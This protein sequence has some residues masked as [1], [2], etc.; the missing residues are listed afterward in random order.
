MSDISFFSSEDVTCPVCLTVFKREVIRQGGGRFIPED[1]DLDLYRN[2]KVTEKYGKVCPLIFHVVVCPSCYFAAMSINDFKSIE[3]EDVDP[4]KESENN[5]IE[6]AELIFGSIFDFRETRTLF[7][8]VI[9]YFL[10]LS[11]YSNY[12]IKNKRPITYKKAICALRLS[13]LVREVIYKEKEKKDGETL[14]S[15]AEDIYWNFRV[16]ARNLYYQAYLAFSNDKEILDNK[17]RF[18]PDVD[19]DFGYDGFLYVLGYLTYE[20]RSMLGEE[21]NEQ[22]TIIKRELGRT[23]G[24]G[25]ASKNKPSI[26][27]YKVKDLVQ[28][29][30]RYNKQLKNK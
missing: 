26:L 24:L 9:A 20:Q 4:I 23:F 30:I 8:G 27:L 17:S 16:L 6:K 19:T 7:G 3:S 21:G 13:W 10:A 11:C 29:I 14:F 2:Y 5:R 15:N 25:K 1:M 22:L 12:S 18:G 28:E